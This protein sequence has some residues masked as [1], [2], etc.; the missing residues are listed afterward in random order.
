[1]DLRTTVRRKSRVSRNDQHSFTESPRVPDVRAISAET[2]RLTRLRV[3]VDYNYFILLFTLPMVKVTVKA[4][5][6]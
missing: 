5:Y 3:N 4:T 1:M 2:R 6:D